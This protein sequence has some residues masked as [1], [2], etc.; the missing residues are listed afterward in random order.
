M[1]LGIK[2][3][4]NIRKKMTQ[5]DFLGKIWVKKSGL[6]RGQKGSKGVKNVIFRDFLEN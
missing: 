4:D 2:L 1:K 5:P 6:K 3:K